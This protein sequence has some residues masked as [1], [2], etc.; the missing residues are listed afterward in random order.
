M[1]V[2]D[3]MEVDMMLQ[4]AAARIHVSAADLVGI[5]AGIGYACG[6]E[7]V[8]IGELRTTAGLALGAEA[9]LTL[10]LDGESDS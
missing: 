2:K 10:M 8:L 6:E 1:E 4:Q 3:D 9:V 7:Q 5:V